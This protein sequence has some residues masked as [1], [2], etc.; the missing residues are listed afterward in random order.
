MYM[1]DKD[2]VTSHTEVWI[3][4]ERAIDQSIKKIVTSHTEVWIEIE[5]KLFENKAYR[6]HL[7][8]GGVD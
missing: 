7:P 8:Y 2:I 3:E 4:I 6:S 1:D 5:P